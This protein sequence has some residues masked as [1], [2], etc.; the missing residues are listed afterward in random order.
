LNAQAKFAEDQD[1]SEVKVRVGVPEDVHAVMAVALR[2]CEENGYVQANPRKLLDHVWAAL[3][4]EHGIMGV[5]GPVG[6]PLEG[7]ILLRIGSPWY[8]DVQVLEEKS[9]WVHPD[10]REAKGGRASRLAEFSRKT[11]ESLDIPMTI[12]ILSSERT[13]AK[14]RLYTRM[15]GP[16]AG[17]Y[18]LVGVKTGEAFSP[19]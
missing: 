2:V 16:P 17:A 5:I 4:L 18:W 11:R 9:L 10:H 15:F 13:E 14:I 3:N 6:G 8:S 12:G 19:I 1:A 7:V